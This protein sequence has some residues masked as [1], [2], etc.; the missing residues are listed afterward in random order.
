MTT[1]RLLTA[2]AAAAFLALPLATTADTI[3]LQSGEKIDCTVLEETPEYV[4][5]EFNVTPSIIDERKIL[6]SAGVWDALSARLA[7][8]AGFST[9]EIGR[10]SCRERV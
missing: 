5:I 9:V 4:H 8:R 7:E 10:A 3:I 2:L 1:P 6:I